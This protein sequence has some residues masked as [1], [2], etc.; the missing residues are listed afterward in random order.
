MATQV[1]DSAPRGM[2]SAIM[3]RARRISPLTLKIM[4]INV[5]ALIALVVGLFFLDDYRRTQIDVRIDAM[6][7]AAALMAGEVGATA[8][9]V[10][11]TA[12]GQQ[13]RLAA[14]LAR[15]V[16]RRLAE[17]TRLRARLFA[18]T[19]EQMV[20]TRVLGLASDSVEIA[21]LPPHAA[22]PA[23]IQRLAYRLYDW[24]A[25]LL[26]REAAPTCLESALP[27][28][29]DYPE[30]RASLQGEIVVTRCADP[31]DDSL[32]LSVSVPVQR[33]REVLGVLIVSTDS[34][35]IELAVRQAR[36]NIL[37]VF[38]IVLA[39]TLLVSAYLAGTIAR[40]IVRLAQ[41][42]DRVSR[43]QGLG[44][45]RNDHHAPPQIP[46]MSRR[47]DEIGDLSG[48]L[49]DMTQALWRRLDAIE[50]FAA[51]VSHEIKNPLTSLKSAVETA[52]RV[53]DPAQR[54]RLMAIVT[55]DVKRIDRLLADIS[56]ASRLDAELSRAQ[57][58][59]VDLAELLKALADISASTRGEGDPRIVLRLADGE[60]LVAPG[61]EDRLGQVFRNVIR[62]A[63][64]FSPRDG[65]ITITAARAA[66][67]ITVT[68]DDQGPGVPEDRREKI[69]DRFYSE[70]PKGEEFGKHSGLGL[71][72]SRQIIDAH[73]GHI[74]AENRRDAAGAILGARFTIQ[75]PTH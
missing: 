53:S 25:D 7:N 19:N 12:T 75:L 23:A 61:L 69:F 36:L 73:G 40:P 34:T 18:A 50:R 26:P 4:G 45:S 33:Y 67:S 14:E 48:A 57:R 42:A 24:A 10:T 38:A 47:H 28:L 16:L 72:I 27:S 63:E 65:T 20:D 60:K 37:K 6:R 44:A 54:E 41:A 68:I 51:D 2:P 64:T 49:S 35:E 17:Q 55:D 31:D 66:D 74:G 56:S 11:D 39:L 52:A 1:G 58:L 32:V 43:G 15:G 30:S 62:N 13:E 9:T 59:P 21:A 70:R 8:T 22:E 71:S 3:R 46:D 5:L 29:I